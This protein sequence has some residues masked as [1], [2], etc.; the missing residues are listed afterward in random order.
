[1]SG[2]EKRSANMGHDRLAQIRSHL[3]TQTTEALEEELAELMLEDS[4]EALDLIDAYVEELDKRDP[5]IPASTAEDSLKEFQDKYST[6]FAEAVSVADK[7]SEEKSRPI[8]RFRLARHLSIAAIIVVMVVF[9]AVQAS[10]IN[11][12]DAIARWTSETFGF[13]SYGE[14][15]EGVPNTEY[16][17]LLAAL[18]R[19]EIT[20]VNIPSYLPDGYVQAELNVAEDGSMFVAVYQSED[21]TIAIQLRM[22]T[23]DTLGSIEK[24]NMNP[25]VYPVNGVD[26]YIMVNTGTYLAAWECNG[27]ECSIYGVPSEDELY[28]MINSIY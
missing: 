2:Q 13:V 10:G 3:A 7:T 16:N 25:I 12:L 20:D 14:N 6:L 28:A 24:D 23:D 11:I 21:S 9:F 18:D 17:E 1:M 22:K 8:R 5:C 27:Y 19:Y 15:A 26:H 4:D